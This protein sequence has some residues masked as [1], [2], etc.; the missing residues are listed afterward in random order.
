[1][2][3]E[4]V[5]VVLVIPEALGPATSILYSVAADRVTLASIAA[6]ASEAPWA[7]LGSVVLVSRRAKTNCANESPIGKVMYKTFPYLFG[8]HAWNLVGAAM[9]QIG[10]DSARP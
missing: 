3:P 6:E 1:M 9:T 7:P 10:P 4:G 5:H 8:Q 2:N